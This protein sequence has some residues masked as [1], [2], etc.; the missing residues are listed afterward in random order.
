M[1]AMIAKLRMCERSIGMGLVFYSSIRNERNDSC[2]IPAKGNYESVLLRG[3][4]W[5]RVVNGVAVA[6]SFGRLLH[7]F[8]PF[9]LIVQLGFH[10]FHM[11]QLLSL[12]LVPCD[13][14]VCGIVN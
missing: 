10:P 9:F 6:L 8:Q 2:W 7:F 14:P 1:W 11:L 4:S 5:L 3:G 12:V 13:V